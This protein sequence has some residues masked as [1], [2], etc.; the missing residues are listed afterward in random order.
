VN[1]R[2]LVVHSDRKIYLIE[3]LDS[4]YEIEDQLNVYATLVHTPTNVHTYY[5]DEFSLWSATLLGYKEKDILEFLQYNSKNIL[6][7]GIVEYIKET[8]KDLWTMEIYVEADIFK[9]KGNN[10]AIGKILEAKELKDKIL[11]KE[12][13]IV[14]FEKRDLYD[15]RNFLL[16]QNVYIIE[17]TNKFNHCNLKINDN[18]T[19]YR[20]Q[21][22]AVNKFINN[23]NISGRG[24]I[25]MP[26]GSEKTL[27]ALKII[28]LLKV[29]TLILVNHE[30]RYFRWL[31]EIEEKTNFDESYVAYNDFGSKKPICICTY[32]YAASVLKDENKNAGWGFIVYDDANRLPAKKASKTA[33]ITSKYKLAMDSILWRSDN[34]E[35]LIFKA[36]GPKVFNLTLRKLEEQHYQIKVKCYEVK[37]PFQSWEIAKEGSLNHTVSK[38]L[39]KIYAYK[40]ISNK[41]RN[42]QKVLVSHFLKVASKFNDILMIPL[43]NGKTDYEKKEENIHL[44][45]S[46]IKD[47]IVFTDVF[48]NQ[49]LKDI[50][51]LI[52]LSYNGNSEREEYLRIGKLK[53]SNKDRNIIGFYYALVSEDTEEDEIYSTRRNRMLKYGYSFRIITLDELRRGVIEI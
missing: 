2:P 48:E 36:I 37:V 7:Q 5:L 12:K 23:K 17:K 33:Y 30:K 11:W 14:S 35:Q 51:V 34:N 15:I 42:C 49:F 16:N 3:K 40:Y 4:E 39:N 41:H 6:P 25:T 21:N 32:S 27:V 20:Y 38:N 13:G 52:S 46:K 8:I 18:V 28:E 10:R 19:L 22:E 9:L 26:P 45:N 47:S 43:C 31:E 1:N 53:A 29:N 50:D 44:F 24:V